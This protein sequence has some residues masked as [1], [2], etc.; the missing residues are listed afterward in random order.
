MTYRRPGPRTGAL[1]FRLGLAAFVV[2]AGLV[3]L[4]AQRVARGRQP[5]ASPAPRPVARPVGSQPGAVSPQGVRTRAGALAEA[6]VRGLSY[7]PGEVLVKFRDRAG[8]RDPDRALAAVRSQSAVDELRW[9]GDVALVKD[10][11]QPDAISLARRLAAHPDVEFAEPNYLRRVAGASSD[12]WAAIRPAG[13]QAGAPAGVPSDPDYGALQWNLSLIGMP[14]AWDINPG[15]S[16]SLTVAVLDTGVTTA[17]ETIVRR[18]WT[19]SSFEMVSLRFDPSP[20]ITASRFTQPRDFTSANPNEPVRD[21]NGH[22]THVA[23]TLAEDT[24]NQLALAGIAYRVRVM[25]IKVCLG[26][27]DLMIGLAEVGTPGFLPGSAGSCTSAEVAAGIR[28]AVDNGARVINV[29]ISGPTPSQVERDALVYAAGQGAFVALAAGNEFETGNPVQYPAAF[30]SSIDG[31]ISVG[32]V[33]KSLTRAYY[34]STGTY[35][36]ATAPGGSSRD[37]DGEDSGFIWQVTLFPLDTVPSI[38]R[39]RF[40]RYAEVGYSGTSMAAPHAAGVAALLMSQG[41][42]NPRAI[43]AFLKASA[44]DLGQSGTDTQF[45]HGLLQGRAAVFGQGVWR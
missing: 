38:L 4:R 34:S 3:D 25:P 18:L 6:R 9:I 1:L 5:L 39:P 37:G 11:A 2:L 21:L 42:S 22:G 40:D 24:N 29:S 7:V 13:S 33:G 36:E 16:P 45:G 26:Y 15:G 27:W 8:R 31:V 17:A 12:Q 32:A 35:I 10:P 30:A 44:R 20:D 19:G 41:V 14:A 28:Y 23:S 43:E